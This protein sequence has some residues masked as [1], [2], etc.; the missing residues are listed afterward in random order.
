MQLSNIALELVTKKYSEAHQNRLKHT[1][2]V[3]KMAKYLANKLGADEDKAL[4][5]AY[6]HDYAKYDDYNDYLDLLTEAEIKECNE[7]P[8][9]YHAYISAELFKKLI[10]DDKDIYNAIK[11]H[12]FGRYNM[13]L[14][15]QIIMIS[16]Y[17]EENRTYPTCIECRNILLDGNLDLAILKSTEYTIDFANKNNSHAHPEQIKILNYYREKLNDIK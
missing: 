1:L 16:D 10:C 3:A 9:L 4:A 12:V 5:A 7:Y 8:F 6:M 15:E 13:S 14:L 2:G 11:Y 17:T